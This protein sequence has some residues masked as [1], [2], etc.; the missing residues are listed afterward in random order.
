M[1]SETFFEEKLSSDWRPAS[2]SVTFDSFDEVPLPKWTI[3]ENFRSNSN[4]CM[5]VDVRRFRRDNITDFG[6]RQVEILRA[7]NF[8]GCITT[9]VPG[10]V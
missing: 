7:W 3:P 8:T 10:G 6:E 2:W 1:P 9:N 4:S 5:L